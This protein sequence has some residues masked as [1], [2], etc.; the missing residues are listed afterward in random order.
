M[1]FGTI[2]TSWIT[3]AFIDAAN[4]AD[5]F[6]LAAVYSRAEDK[7]KQFAE[8]NNAPHYFTDLQ[9]MAASDELDCVYI[10]SP[11]SLHFE[12]A[13]L[14]LKHKKHVICEKPIFSNTTEL[15]EAHRIA[16]ENEVYL[17]EAMRNIHSP[18]F[19]RL[20]ENIK[21]IGTVRSMML[22]RVQYSSR[23]DKYLAGETPNIFSAEFSGGA[24]VDLGIYP[25]SIAVA[26]F[27]KPQRVTYFPVILKSG[28]DGNGTLV[29]VYPDFTCTIVCSKISN[30]FNPN[31]I[32]GEEGT[33]L[34]GDSGTLTN[35][36]LVKTHSD[37]KVILDTVVHEHDMV[38][39]IN[40]F[41]EIIETENEQEYKRLKEL[42][43]LV[44]SITEE[45][46]KQSGIVFGVER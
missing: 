24:L 5:N 21:E 38:F 41:Q 34:F 30:S 1:K 23:Y 27:G 17:F 10:A 32:H 6:K 29:L 36:A 16:E 42:N 28:I 40:H 43:Y 15:Q 31:E 46:R 9:Q 39:E 18:N 35:Q 2:G 3:E 14:F 22:Q 26:L 25:L 44:L 45:A 7:A 4:E 20:Q 8:K 37:E 19:L 12:Q 13:V 11:N 33:L